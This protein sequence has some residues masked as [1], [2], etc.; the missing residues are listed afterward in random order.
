MT[1]KTHDD[2]DAQS[3]H[4]M[5]EF[6]D[7]ITKNRETYSRGKNPNSLD[8]LKPHQYKTGESGNVGGRKP[9]YYQLKVAL[10]RIGDEDLMNF[11]MDGRRTETRREKVLKKIWCRAEQGDL[12]FIQL[13]ANI[14]CLDERT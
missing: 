8:A 10:N 13:L 14:G 7:S 1:R 3:V 12:K 5:D 6:E 4:N 9:Q 11:D 2:T